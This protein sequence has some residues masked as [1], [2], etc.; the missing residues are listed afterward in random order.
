MRGE[1]QSPEEN[2]KTYEESQQQ[3]AL[4]RKVRNEKLKLSVMQAQGADEEDIQK[5]K[6]KVRAAS[7]D[8]Q[9][10]CDETGR[11]RRKSR[12]YTPVNAKFPSKDSYDPATFRT[13]QRDAI[14]QWA[15]GP[16]R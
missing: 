12:E 3:R 4:E 10:F 15:M 13:E 2:E 14:R 5:Q 8:V 7:A 1:P 11:T 6:A 9:A 16:R